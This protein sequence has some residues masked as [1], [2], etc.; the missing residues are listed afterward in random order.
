MSS[1]RLCGVADESNAHG[2][3]GETHGRIEFDN[4]SDD[5]DQED[6]SSIPDPKEVS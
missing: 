1:R 5:N 2:T 3:T 4:D 6:D